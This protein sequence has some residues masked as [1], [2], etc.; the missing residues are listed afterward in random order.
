VAELERLG[1]PIEYG[2]PFEEAKHRHATVLY[3]GRLADL[4]P[5]RLEHRGLYLVYLALPIEKAGPYETYYC[6]EQR[7][8]FG[9]VSE[10]KHYSAR[11]ARPGETILVV[12]VPE[13]RWGARERFDEEPLRSRLLAQLETAGIVPAGVAPAEMEQRFLPEVYPLHDRGWVARWR[14]ALAAVERLGNVLPFGRQ[15]LFAHSNVHHSVSLADAVVRHA[16]FCGDAR[17][18]IRGADRFLEL[19]VRD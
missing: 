12:E 15:G 16:L 10:L 14:E 4:V 13:G 19:R 1:V 2:T 17:G 8:W 11:L 18:W 5:E 7:F 3:S 9:R 6:P